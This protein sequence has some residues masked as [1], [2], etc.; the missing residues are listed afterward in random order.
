MERPRFSVA[1]VV[2]KHGAAFEAAHGQGATS[3]Q[4]RAL[5]DIV[6][7][8]TAVLGGHVEVYACGHEVTAYN[9]CRSRHCPKCLAHKSRAWVDAR[10]R[11]LAW[12]RNRRWKSSGGP[13]GGNPTLMRQ[14]ARTARGVQWKS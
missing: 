4:R 1:D 6:R 7:C 5:W 14:G 8:R 2:R 11:D 13:D 10:E 9:S 12:A 3:D